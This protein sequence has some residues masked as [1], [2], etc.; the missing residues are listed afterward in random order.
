MR[1][2]CDHIR[3]G[4]D[5]GRFSV[6]ERTISLLKT[7]WVLQFIFGFFSKCF[8]RGKQDV[9]LVSCCLSTPSMSAAPQVFPAWLVPSLVPLEGFWGSVSQSVGNASCLWLLTSLL[10][11]WRLWMNSGR[12]LWK[13]HCWWRNCLLF[14][15]A[16][17]PR[18]VF[19]F[20]CCC[21]QLPLVS[22]EQWCVL[23]WPCSGH[24]DRTP[25]AVCAL[26]TS[27]GGHCVCHVGPSWQGQCWCGGSRN[28]WILLCERRGSIQRE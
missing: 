12:R 7:V 1:I 25:S 21:H 28:C 26:G 6:D 9:L 17:S 19:V 24:C 16:K 14:I 20:N 15:Y 13:L 3:P 22:L 11:P 8:S 4:E 27:G 10:E 23:L 2:L 5:P 18:S